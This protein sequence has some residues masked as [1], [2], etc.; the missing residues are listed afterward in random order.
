MWRSLRESKKGFDIVEIAG[1]YMA[2][3]V[4]E[5]SQEFNGVVALT[6]ATAFILK[7]LDVPKGKDEL[8]QLLLDEYDADK[9]TIERD[10]D[11]V[12]QKMIGIGLIEP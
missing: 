12:I 4:G 9:A 10:L 8:T 3:P 1:E 11:I 6:E 5:T 7:H 2:V